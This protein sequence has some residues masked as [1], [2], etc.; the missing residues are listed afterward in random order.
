MKKIISLLLALLMLLP[1]LLLGGCAG[2]KPKLDE[3]YDRVVFLIEASYELNVIFYGEG[4]PYYDRNL[5]IYESLYNNY[6]TQQYTRTHN[7]VS[8]Q[9]KYLSIEEIK[10]AAEQVY[11]KEL[12]EQTVYPAAFDGLMVMSGGKSEYSPA[13]YLQS[14]EDLYILNKESEYK[15]TPLVYDYGSMKIIRPSNGESVLISITVWEEGKPDS[16]YKTEIKLAKVD[17]VWYLD[18][19]TV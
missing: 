4:L 8:S 5:P 1:C 7:I 16:A 19:L 10:Y 17:G 11:T 12:L 2:R 18:K 13:R 14:N 9:A 15:L 3:I 6:E